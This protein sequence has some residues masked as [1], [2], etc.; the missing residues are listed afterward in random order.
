MEK[1][2]KKCVLCGKEFKGWGNNPYPLH[3]EG[4]CCDECNTTKV[5]P[6]R[7]LKMYENKK[8]N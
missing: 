5:I 1:E 2:L 8:E 6:A 3:E 4:E 7:I